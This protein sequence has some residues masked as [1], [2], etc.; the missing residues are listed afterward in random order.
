MKIVGAYLGF[1]ELFV[2]QCGCGR[3]VIDGVYKGM[4]FGIVLPFQLDYCNTNRLD[5]CFFPC[6]E[7]NNGENLGFSFPC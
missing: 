2:K 5:L 7:G 6:K 1:V 4:S 3:Y